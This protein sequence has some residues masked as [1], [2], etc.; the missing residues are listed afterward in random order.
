MVRTSAD[1]PDDITTRI[2]H[3][4]LATTVKETDL[5][6]GQIIA[7]KAAAIHTEGLE[8]VA[9]L[10][11]T[12]GQGETDKASIE[13]GD[14]RIPANGDVVDLFHTHF[15]FTIGIN[16]RLG[17]A[18]GRQWLLTLLNKNASAVEKQLVGL[19]DEATAS[20]GVKTAGYLFDGI[21]RKA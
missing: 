15:T 11:G 9:L 8:T 3:E 21:G 16:A 6:V 14:V 5:A 10:N 18:Q 7:D 1:E 12:D 4:K 13:C 19:G 2:S 17:D 20:L